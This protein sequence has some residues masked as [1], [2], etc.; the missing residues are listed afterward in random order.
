MDGTLLLLV[1][2]KEMISAMKIIKIR[3][4]KYLNNCIE[5][6][7]RN[8]KPIIAIDTGSKKLEYIRMTLADIDLLS[9]LE[10]IK[11]LILRN[12]IQNFPFISLI[13][14]NSN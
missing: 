10:R 14:S 4:S 11:S 8:I 6:D 5:Q 12:P 1:P 7:H 13:T 2:L 9:L 3:K